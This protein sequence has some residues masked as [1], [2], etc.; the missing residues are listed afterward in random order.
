[1]YSIQNAWTVWPPFKVSG[2]HIY[3]VIYYFF[4]FLTKREG[5]TA[6]ALSQK[7]SSWRNKSEIRLVTL[8]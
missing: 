7:L 6:S 5:T 8:P 1:M 3:H 4:F 2:Q